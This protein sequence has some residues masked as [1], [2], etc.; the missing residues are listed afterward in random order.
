MKSLFSYLKNNKMPKEFKQ[1]MKTTLLT[2]ENISQTKSM[3]MGYKN[4]LSNSA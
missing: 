4:D 2:L 1:S 3:Q